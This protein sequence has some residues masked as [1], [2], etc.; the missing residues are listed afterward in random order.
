MSS[1]PA[2]EP[3]VSDD[4]RVER[5][6]LGFPVVG[7][8]AS[9]GGMAAVTR[10]LQGLPAQ[11]GMAFVV[12]LHLSPRHESH[13]A[14]ILQRATSLVVRQVTGRVA[15]QAEH[16]YVIPPTQQM[17]MTD[18]HLALVP[19]ERIDGRPV[20]IDAFFRT[21]AE[22]H[23]ERAV[24]IVLSGAGSDGAVGITRLK[25]EGGITLAQRPED[26]EH[27]SMPRAAIAT[28][29][30]DFVLPVGEM[31]PKLL[32]LAATARAIRL[33]ADVAPSLKAAAIEP[34]NESL[35]AERA[36]RDIMG[37]LRTRTHHNFSHY[38]RSTVLRRIERRMQVT[39]LSRLPAYRDHLREH[40]EETAPL[41]QDMLISVTHFFRDAHAFERLEREVLPA[42]FDQLEEGQTLRAWAAGCATGEEAYSLAMGLRAEADR[43]TDGAAF[44]VFASDIDDRALATARAGR[45]PGAIAADVEPERLRRFFT[46][47]GH[48][49]AIL[50]SLRDR[51]LFAHHN[52]LRDPPFSRLQLISCR[53]L[54]IYLE[55]DAQAAVLETFRFALAPGGVLFLGSSETVDVAP[56]LF[57]PIDKA[58]RIYRAESGV[59]ARR[60]L[61][62]RQLAPAPPIPVPVPLHLL[63]SAGQGELPF[64]E[65]HHRALQSLLPASALVDAE[66]NILHL[67]EGAGRFL[68][69]PSGLPSINLVDNAH[70]Q[71]RLE[72]RAALFKARQSAMVVEARAPRG[73]DGP[74]AGVQ[75]T[76]RPVR[77]Q[78]SALETYLVSLVE[79]P[80]D[81]VVQPV[82]DAGARP[83]E[84][85]LEAEV[86]RLRDRLQDTLE[87]AERTTQDLKSSNEELQA[88]N[89]ELRSAT[90]ELETSKEELQSTN[91]ELV[92]VNQELA[93]R[94]EE[95][96]RVNDDLHNLI[97]STDIATV[98][99]DG[100]MRIKR[101]TPRAAEL[102][103]LIAG[104]L[105]R[106]LLDLT[107]KLVYDRLATDASYAFESLRPV[108][109]EIATLDGRVMLA[110]FLPYRT[111]ADRIEGVV[112]TFIDIT[113]RHQAE[114]EARAGEERLRIAV[115]STRDFAIAVTD[116]VGIV[117]HW[118]AGAQRI[119]GFEAA[120]MVGRSLAIVFT[121]EDQARGV[122]QEEMRK[123]EEQGRAEDERW[124]KRKDG[125]VFYCSGVMTPFASGEA[126]GFSKI[127]RDMT[128]SKQSE[129]AREAQL[130]Q[131]QVVRRRAEAAMESKEE[132]LAV[133]SHELKHPL[134]LI[135]LNAELLMRLPQVRGV[136]QAV[137]A[138]QTIQ[139]TVVA[140]AKIVDDLL[141]LSRARTGKL[142]LQLAPVDWS[143]IV[144]T[145]VEA[146]QVDARVKGVELL[147]SGTEAPLRS[148]F[149]RVRAEQIVWNLLSNALKFTPAGGR[150]RVALAVEGSSVRLTVADTGK[151]I[152][153][154]FVGQVFEMFSQETGPQRRQEG[155][156]GVGLALVRELATAHGG[157]VAVESAGLGRGATFSV[158]VPQDPSA[159]E[160]PAE[161]AASGVLAGLHILLVDD[162]VDTLTPLAVLMELYGAVVTTADGGHAALQS[163]GTSSFDI[164][165]SDIS[166]P[167]MTGF[168]LI[169]KVRAME[170][171]RQPLAV[172]CSGY[173]RAQD[174]QRALEA[175]FDA[176]LTKPFGIV[177]FE[178]LVAD[179]RA[180]RTPG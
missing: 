32:A 25:E 15:I 7:I 176:T 83:A 30:V 115:E 121:D 12:I 153:P 125:S 163:V 128:G 144:H 48:Q 102:F 145:I 177:E 62:L 179:L 155:G 140:Q 175:G 116:E 126:R 6:G 101:Y 59:L 86:G 127:A 100:A 95:T 24:G 171:Q 45:Y 68:Q 52:V 160:E 35:A 4:P 119:F 105:G 123:A 103:N 63:A 17:L 129:L 122:P 36:L 139:R 142:T 107:H 65:L 180:A 39:G 168:E 22:A 3:P 85:A 29:A 108:E 73:D 87:H 42:L 5:S 49:Y 40:P 99:V 138:A 80:P 106:P 178:Q 97:A 143:A 148:I 130:A 137:H 89:E 71:L 14:E 109:R 120:E 10:L 162:S 173:A 77:E 135:S 50:K 28:G 61:P 112:L 159:S 134:N 82:D 110:R 151:G 150:I 23:R 149:D 166:M 55:R 20:A 104:D 114:R 136:E 158:W 66:Y 133:M 13:A 154:S 1:E 67:S 9:A 172:A 88:M 72:L 132:F 58:H 38:K 2:A 69:L 74:G 8:G 84:T 161:P 19:S 54:L 76:V 46:R 27:D 47:D 98:F 26:A 34:G 90:E 96:G 75:I 57:T 118:N 51:T 124:H 43:R 156:L 93:V 81:A 174:T 91:E 141:D 152:A 70:P 169:R 157:R 60:S 37:L 16:V 164:I 170:L 53:N 165:V 94:V 44:Q 11:T 131:E 92:T 31:V 147:L 33:P 117:T 167:D 146:V 21:L 111:A 79:I 78:S 56:G 18:G 64:A 113:A 41:L